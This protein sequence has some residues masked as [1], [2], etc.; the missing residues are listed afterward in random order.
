[1]TACRPSALL[2]AA[3]RAMLLARETL[4]TG[5]CHPQDNAGQHR[6]ASSRYNK[7]MVVFQICTLPR[8]V[9]CC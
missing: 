7:N 4:P 5:V 8:C 3:R 6:F 9:P 2:P 1:M